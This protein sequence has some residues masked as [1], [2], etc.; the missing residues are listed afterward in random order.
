LKLGPYELGPNDT[1]ENGIYCGDAR[2]LAKAIPDESVDLILT[3]PPWGIGFSY[4][5]N[6]DDDPLSYAPLVQWIVEESNRIMRPGAFAFSYQ[7]TKRLRE[8][9]QLFPS[10]SRLF[11]SCKNFIQ[12]KRLAVEYAVDFIVFW[13]K[14]GDFLP[15]G[16]V[17]DWNLCITS[18]TSSG[19]RGIGLNKKTSPP[20]PLDGTMN[21]LAGMCP[22]QG[23]VVDFFLGS[24]T[25]SVAAK[26]LGR[27]YLAFE[28]DPDTCTMARER[29]RNTQPPL[30]IPDPETQLQMI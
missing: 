12:I 25:V 27:N 5:N 29:V 15:R 8:T 9:W 6:Y 18:N 30:F 10:N 14:P 20:R 23:I 3:D 21:I 13:Q 16:L 19:S 28:I 26:R 11:A 24:G 2:E 7:A 4:H 22:A 17:R 1:P